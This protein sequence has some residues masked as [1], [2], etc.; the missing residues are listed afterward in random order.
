[1]SNKISIRCL[2]SL[3]V[4]GICNICSCMLTYREHGR[5]MGYGNWDE[6]HGRWVWDGCCHGKYIYIYL[7]CI[8]YTV[9]RHQ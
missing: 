5:D 3:P 6:E 9:D 2:V 4:V 8:I 7:I 1:M